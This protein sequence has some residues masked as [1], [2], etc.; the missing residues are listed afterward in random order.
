MKPAAKP[1]FKQGKASK[2]GKTA[3]GATKKVAADRG[4]PKRLPPAGGEAPKSQPRDIARRKAAQQL[5][6]TAISA[7]LDKKALA[8]VLLDVSDHASYTDFI[9]VVSGRSDRQVIAIAENVESELK[10]LGRTVIGREG[11]AGGRWSLL[12]FGDFVLH[13]FYHPVREVYDIEGLWIEA[14]RVVL[15][16]VPPEAMQ[17]QTDAMY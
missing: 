10:K 6:E 9:G 13:V 5:A 8:P 17:F 3:T 12:D 15:K 7:A 11:K 4:K 16:N 2:S 14:K 1:V